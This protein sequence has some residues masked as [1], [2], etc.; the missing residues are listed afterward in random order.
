MSTFNCD[1]LEAVLRRIENN[2]RLMGPNEVANICGVAANALSG[3]YDLIRRAHNEL[4]VD[5]EM[6][7]ADIV[8][9]EK[10]VADIGAFI[11]DGLLPKPERHS[12]A[13]SDEGKDRCSSGEERSW[14]RL[15]PI[16]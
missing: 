5:D 12:A 11:T 10:V 2:P 15:K 16:R 3:M 1:A 4:V 6:L 14:A 13:P 7:K 8:V 9:A